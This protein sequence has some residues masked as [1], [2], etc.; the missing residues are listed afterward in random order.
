MTNLH[1][2]LFVVDDF[3]DQPRV[4]H[5]N[6]GGP[7]GGS[8]LISL[9]VRGRHAGLSCAV[10]TKMSKLLGPVIRTQ[11]TFML[12]WRLRNA[13]ELFE[14]VL[15]ELSALYPIKVLQQMYEIAT[16]EKYGFLYVNLQPRSGL[17]EDMF[18]KGF[19][20]RLVP[21][22][23]IGN[24]AEPPTSTSPVKDG[25]VPQPTTQQPRAS[26]KS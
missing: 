5:T 4:V 23:P 22:V 10:S 8:W 25:N 7:D 12:I 1:S 24:A 2:V 14:N 13:K 18:W 26:D 19:Q 11:A 21:R 17:K 3:A 16:S 15:Y 9:F 6:K 20:A